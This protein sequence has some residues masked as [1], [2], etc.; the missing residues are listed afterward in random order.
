[1]F[2]IKEDFINLENSKHIDNPYEAFDFCINESFKSVEKIHSK[3]HKNNLMY[4]AMLINDVK[5]K[6]VFHFK[7]M[8]RKMIEKVGAIIFKCLEKSSLPTDGARSISSFITGT[9]SI[10]LHA[11]TVYEEFDRKAQLD[12]LR[13]I[14]E[15]IFRGLGMSEEAIQKII[16]ES[17]F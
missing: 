7:S 13:E 2:S 9:L 10:Y 8:R 1:M 15:F 3:N 4:Q 16:N 5:D 12:E 14:K 6:M 17:K 11:Q